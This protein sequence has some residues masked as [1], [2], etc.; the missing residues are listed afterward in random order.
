MWVDRDRLQVIDSVLERG[1]GTDVE[2]LLADI[3]RSNAQQS[4]IPSACPT[5][6]R[7]LVRSQLPGAGLY[8][9]ACPDRHGAWMTS[10]VVEGLQ[11][12]VAEH[13]TVAARKRH[14]LRLL[15]RLLIVLAV[16]APVSILLTYPERVIMT[17]VGA[18]ESVYDSRV[19]ETNWPSRGWLYKGELPTKGSTINVHGELQYFHDLLSALDHGITNRLNM[20]GVLKTRRSSAEYEALYDVYRT[21]QLDVLE[22]LRR[23]EVPDRLKQIHARM[24]RATEQ[25]IRFY[26]A[27][28]D[29]KL[30][31]PSVDL[32]RLLGD[33]ALKTVNQELVTAWIEIKRLY[34]NLDYE[35]SRAIESHL[36]AFD[37]L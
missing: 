20:D 8:V 34:P 6:R 25:Q 11:R 17:I 33:S 35:T 4:E 31:D 14:Q 15:N 18:I 9:S 30:R 36:C 27:F 12:F 22:R 37:V 32:G 24:I 26:G 1:Q 5:C 2:Q 23:L 29:A 21:R 7:D 13:A 19:S 3:F 28:V 16:L 10:D